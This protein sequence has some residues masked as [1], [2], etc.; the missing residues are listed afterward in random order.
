MENILTIFPFTKKYP[1]FFCNYQLQSA[2][3]IELEDGWDMWGKSL[4]L[5]CTM[6]LPF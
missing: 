6:G 4:A 3:N 5:R 2:G 1:G